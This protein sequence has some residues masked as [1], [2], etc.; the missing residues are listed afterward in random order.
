[1][2]IVENVYDGGKLPPICFDGPLGPDFLR[3]GF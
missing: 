3:G 2:R 1:M